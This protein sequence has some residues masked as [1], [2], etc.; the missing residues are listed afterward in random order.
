MSR[1]F[2]DITCSF[3]KLEL[4]FI[5]LKL[6]YIPF[7]CLTELG[8][9][10][11]DSEM[12]DSAWEVMARLASVFSTGFWIVDYL[13]AVKGVELSFFYWKSFISLP[14]WAGFSESSASSLIDDMLLYI[15]P[16][17]LN[18]CFYALFW[19]WL[20]LSL[21]DG[22]LFLFIGRLYCLLYCE[23]LVGVTYCPSLCC[24]N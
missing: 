4:V 8:C 13:V 5:R 3:P 24:K 6:S 1:L 19:Y 11:S 15:L 7:F 12:M 22:L 21:D 9:I 20:S 10:W 17:S 2:A 23:N 14:S 18:L 16:S